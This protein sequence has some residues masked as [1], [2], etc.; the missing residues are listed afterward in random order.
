VLDARGGAPETQ[1][2][3]S[4]QKLNPPISVIDVGKD[5]ETVRIEILVGGFT[6]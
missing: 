4:R 2:L 6:E 5:I 1:Q 3:L